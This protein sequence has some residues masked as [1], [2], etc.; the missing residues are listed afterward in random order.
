VPPQTPDFWV[1]IAAQQMLAPGPDWRHDPDN[2]SFVILG[3]LAPGM[4]QSEAQAESSV[5]MR[6]FGANRRERVRTT[7]LTLQ[8]LT[9]FGNTE[10][11]RFQ[12]LAM[13]LMLLAGL[14]LLIACANLAN[15]LLARGA[16]R[17]REF[18]MRLALGASRRRLIRQLLTE[19][20]LLSLPG[21][22]AG[23]LFSSACI[24]MLSLTALGPYFVQS[25][26]SFA[27]DIRIFIYTL[28]LALAAS[29]GFGLSPALQCSRPDLTTALKQEGAAFG[30]RLGRSRLRSILLAGQVAASMLLLITAG[31]LLRGMLRAN[32]AQPG[33][34]AH[35]VYLI[36]AE[37]GALPE[38]AAAT[39]RL[40]LAR[41]AALPQAAAA[42]QGGAPLSGTWTPPIF[43]GG[44][45]A[46][47]LASYAGANYFETLGVPLVRGRSFT[48]ADVQH[49]AAVA[50]ISENTARHFWPG[51]EPIGKR[52]KL[53]M[54]FTGTL[55][56]FQVIGII[57]D[58]RY[59][60]L[61]RTDPS[62]VY[63]PADPAQ[64]GWLLVRFYGDPRAGTGALRSAVEGFD[65][66]LLRSLYLTSI[67]DGPL[68]L[69]RLLAGLCALFAIVLA[70]LALILAA[71][72][73]YG[74][75][76]YLVGRRVREIGVLIAL[77]AD[78]GDVLRSVVLQGL[79]PVM[80][81]CVLGL[82]GAAAASRLIHTTL[83]F[84]GSEDF[85]Y[86]LPYWDPATFVGLTVFLALIAV[87]A[88][89][90]PARRALRVD[91]AVALRCE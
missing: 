22:A 38:K 60:N 24:Q 31:L 40:L 82:A 35:R 2:A 8:R 49:S 15:M 56:E 63:L 84:P 43:T 10:D 70:V 66:G 26:L 25:G 58:I 14:V 90:V 77:G 89:A 11:P 37:F 5:L 41:I 45:R 91:P 87:L 33:F 3:R 7:A 54:H 88:S 50:V 80:I 73:I 29:I 55:K 59:A 75:M 81:G 17:Q 16:A 36:N 67:E 64:P 13:G 69:Q 21:G 20:C 47:T 46:R 85:L 19:G 68:H 42:S 83:S 6:R 39:E 4:T 53:D 61:S 28:L 65:R 27:P 18:A 1:P 71:S 52:F 72:G 23:L 12:A 76:S 79:R 30:G 51:E 62:H 32:D 48:E 86:G 44:L 78:G 74:V 9:Y 34:D 57:R